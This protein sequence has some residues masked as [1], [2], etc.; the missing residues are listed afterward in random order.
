MWGIRSKNTVKQ[1]KKTYKKNEAKLGLP[2]LQEAF[3]RC[4]Y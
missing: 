1:K 4:N 2:H 3:I